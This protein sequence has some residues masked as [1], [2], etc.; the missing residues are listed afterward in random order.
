MAALERE[1]EA[2][3][4]K[5]DAERRRG[6]ELARERDLLTKLRTQA[7]GAS[8]RQVHKCSTEMLIWF[9]QSSGHLPRAACPPPALITRL[10]CCMDFGMDKGQSV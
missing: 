2:L 10:L 7:E 1:A 5:A 8:H 6:E 3:R 4:T 9:T